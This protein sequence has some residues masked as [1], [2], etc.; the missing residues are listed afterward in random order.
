MASIYA[1]RSCSQCLPLSTLQQQEFGKIATNIL[2]KEIDLQFQLEEY[3]SRSTAFFRDVVGTV[4]SNGKCVEIPYSHAFLYQLAQMIGLFISI[5]TIKKHKT[6]M[7][8]DL[9]LYKR[10]S[11]PN[12]DSIMLPKLQMLSMFIAQQD[13]YFNFFTECFKSND[14]L[15]YDMIQDMVIYITYIY[16]KD[17]LVRPEDKT[18]LDLVIY[19]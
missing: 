19:Y 4:C 16:D 3:F 8:N 10:L 15:I 9:A 7:N 1:Y 17:L 5:D 18:R 6:L 13:N 11:A 14:G 12:L 2:K